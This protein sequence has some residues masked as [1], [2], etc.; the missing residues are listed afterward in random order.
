MPAAG[1]G[2]DARGES[3]AMVEEIVQPPLEIGRGSFLDERKGG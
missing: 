3:L 1:V 2:M